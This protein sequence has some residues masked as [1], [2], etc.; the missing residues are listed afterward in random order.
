MIAYKTTGLRFAPHLALLSIVFLFSSCRDQAGGRTFTVENR[1]LLEPAA[2]AEDFLN[3]VDRDLKAPFINEFLP[4]IYAELPPKDQWPAIS[5][6]LTERIDKPIDASKSK[7]LSIFKALLERDSAAAEQLVRKM[8]SAKKVSEHR[9]EEALYALLS[10]STDIPAS[11]KWIKQNHPDILIPRKPYTHSKEEPLKGWEKALAENKVE[12]G[13]ALLLSAVEKANSPSDKAELYSTM[14]RL[15]KVLE[16]QSLIAV[17]SLGLLDSLHADIQDDGRFSSYNYSDLFDSAARMKK[18][19]YIISEFENLDAA[20]K[21]KQKKDQDDEL[22]SS[23]QIYSNYLAALLKTESFEKFTQEIE[24]SKIDWEEM[25]YDDFYSLLA[26]EIPGHA[27]LGILY[28]D[29]LKENNKEAPVQDYALHLLARNAGKDAFYEYLLKL[30]KAKAKTFFAKLHQYDPFEERP[31]IWLAEIARRD[32]DLKT[33]KETIDRAIALDPSDGD[34]GKDTRMFCYEI[35][36]RVYSDMGKDNEAT[37]YRSIVDSIRQGE[38]ADDFLYAGLIKEATDRYKKALR[39]FSDAYCLQSRLAMTLA[40]SGKFKEAAI[41]FEKAFELMPVSFGPRESHCFGCEGLF[42]DPRVIEIALPLLKE[43]QKKNPDNP[44]VPYLLGLVLSEKGEKDQAA[45]AYQKAF[46]L[47]PTYYNAASKLLDIIKADPAKHHQAEELMAQIFEIAP[48]SQ[49]PSY[50]ADAGDLH[51]F[52]DK[53]ENF[54]PSPLDLP[55]NPIKV[56]LP[57]NDTE[58]QQYKKS[59]DMRYM[60]FYLDPEDGIDGWS[61]SELR[62]NNSF[63]NAIEDLD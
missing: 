16:R 53:T 51:A 48:Y 24:Q 26:T 41:H 11:I 60:Y 37:K 29:F 33:A 9:R 34:H 50:I 55:A 62:R 58:K 3:R 31:L 38:A 15:G 52:W 4:I 6:A 61:A 23:E 22:R 17:G 59:S 44:R 20:A 45:I 30:D 39:Q 40:K 32:G 27:P 46:E 36:A 63:L 19:D 1:Q 18:W 25:T 56:A 10:V 35:L 5:Q 49:K 12:Q 47:D 8:I 2:D 7:K 42:N 28:L 14:M 57:E 54:P 21:T 13:I 43:F